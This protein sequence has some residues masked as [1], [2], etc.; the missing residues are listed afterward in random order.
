MKINPKYNAK[1]YS[2][3]CYQLAAYRAALGIEVRCLNLIVNSVVPE[4]PIEHVWGE[5]EMEAGWRAFLAVRELWVIE[6]GYD[7][8][9]KLK[10]EIGKAEMVLTA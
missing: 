7:P 9:E 3:W 6:K 2:T 10:A 4:T 1:P 5:A 8:C